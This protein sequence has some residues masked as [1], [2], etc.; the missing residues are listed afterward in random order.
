MS[1]IEFYQ[2]CVIALLSSLSSIDATKYKS[3]SLKDVPEIV[4]YLAYNSVERCRVRF[5]EIQRP[6]EKLEPSVIIEE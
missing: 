5:N 6:E 2:Q 4:D 1:E 3:I